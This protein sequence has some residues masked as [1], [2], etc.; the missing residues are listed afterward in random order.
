MTVR[1]THP[2]RVARGGAPRRRSGLG[3]SYVDG[4]WTT[5]DLR[6]PGAPPRPQPRRLRP[7]PQPLD[8]GDL[9]GGRHVAP[10]PPAEQARGTAGRS[11]PTTTWA[12]TSS[13]C[14]STRPWR[15][16]AGCSTSP[17]ATLAQAQVD[18]V[19]PPPALDRPPARRAPR[20]DR[21]R[22]GRPGRPRRP[23]LR[24]PGH[25]HH[26]QRRAAPLRHRAGRPSSASQ[27]QVTVL[28][29]DYRD[30]TGTY[31][32]LVSVEMI[33]A[34]DWRDH[35]TFFA[36]LQPA[37]GARRPHGASRPSPWPTAASTGSATPRT[38]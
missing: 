6:R 18:Q 16:P 4:W 1:L 5:D 36:H 32:K 8:P 9:A 14:S 2:G 38:S 15:T 3:E 12:T 11:P 29:E 21:H 37:A 28:L 31:D 22:L 27:D 19:R 34:V 25:H 35:D 24:R 26:D 23:D 10:P 7:A 17:D 30:L 33:E 13:S 20:G